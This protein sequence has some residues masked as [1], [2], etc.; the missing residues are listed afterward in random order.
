VAPDCPD[1]KQTTLDVWPLPLEP[2][3]PPGERRAARLPIASTSCPPLHQQDV[4]PL[5]LSGVRDGAIIKRLPGE[6][7]AAVALQTNGGE[8]RRWWFIN[9]EPTDDTGANVTLSLD[10][11]GEYQLVVMDEAGQVAAATF[12]LQ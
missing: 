9:G 10:K 1:A 3:L 12:T 8:G 5:T 4:I 2:W 6:K 11:A 7:Q